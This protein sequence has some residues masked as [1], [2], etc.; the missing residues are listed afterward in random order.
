MHCRHGLHQKK[1]RRLQNRYWNGRCSGLS[2]D[3]PRSCS[4]LKIQAT[5][6][7]VTLFEEGSYGRLVSNYLS[8]LLA[9]YAIQLSRTRSEW[10]E[11][12]WN[13]YSMKGERRRG[14]MKR[15]R[16]EHN[17]CIQFEYFTTVRIL[18]R[19]KET[20]IDI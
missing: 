2:C 10:Q 13:E 8:P 17:D 3:S 12:S 11:N 16:W 19:L 4:A 15:V 5:L 18:Q 14:W 6:E 1:C 7:I 9:P 20:Y